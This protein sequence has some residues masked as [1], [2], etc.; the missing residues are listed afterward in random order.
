[1][2]QER[3]GG[4]LLTT[5]SLVVIGFGK[6]SVAPTVVDAVATA[7]VVVVLFVVPGSLC[8]GGVYSWSHASYPS[9]GLAAAS[10]C[11]ALQKVVCV[12]DLS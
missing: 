1:M 3:L 11:L 7:V 12:K 8:Q 4:S 6:V 10:T 5:S 2:R 9:E